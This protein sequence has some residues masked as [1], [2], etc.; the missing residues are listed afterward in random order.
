MSNE[1]IVFFKNLSKVWQNYKDYTY[2]EGIDLSEEQIN[3]IEQD[4]DQLLIE[5]YAGT[6]KSLTLL[7]KFIN[8]LIRE[9]GKKILFVTF[10]DTLIADTKKR[11]ES[12]KDYLDNKDRHFTKIQTFHEMA[13]DILKQ[14]K[15]IDRG[16]GR[17]T[18]SKVNKYRDTSLRRIA[19]IAAK[20]TRQDSIDYKQL[21][22]EERLYNTHEHNFITDEIAWIKAMGLIQK[23][24]YL[25]TERTGRSKSI[26][27]TRAQRSTIFKIYEEYE[28]LKKT[29]F[30]KDLDLE[31]YAL[32]I[33]ENSYLIEDEK[34]DYI[35]VDEVQDLDPMQIKALCLLTK[36][37]IVLSGA[38]KQRIYKKSPIKYE[39]L[40]LRI[41]EKG[42][43]KIL[44]K[45]YRSTAEIVR[46]ANSL[47][48]LDDDDKLVE[49]QF[50]RAGD[51]PK[52]HRISDPNK[53]IKYIVDEIKKIHK[54]DEYKTVAVIHR[55]E[56]KDTTGYKSNTRLY[57]EQQLM[58]SIIDIDTY[59]KKFTFKEKKQVIYTNAYDV[60]GLEF[61]VVFIIDFRSLYYPNKKEIDRIKLKNEG[62]DESLIEQ[63]ILE[64]IN[65][66]KKLL[67]VAMTRAKDKLYLVA[68]GCKEDKFISRFITDFDPHYYEANFVKSQFQ[69]NKI[70]KEKIDVISKDEKSV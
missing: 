33:I 46:L 9:E 8:V 35:F 66:E 27:L 39:D 2:L 21:P 15:I 18:V 4:E 11:L 37:S 28:E 42:K 57:L 55:E 63:D 62:K 31:D 14:K 22:R 34:F 23:D 45:N 60:K 49:K 43:R 3:I 61:D 30:H 56:I 16:V 17:L 26:R 59:G 40:G 50:V 5:G 51:R 6:G 70:S 25:E 12:S 67:Y 1:S 38:A 10:N 20:Y 58:N 52:I 13:S 19:G 48:F 41:R 32:S 64:F 36:K 29:R 47:E 54:E 44:N 68:N 53:G 69:S 65:R 24:K 7:Y